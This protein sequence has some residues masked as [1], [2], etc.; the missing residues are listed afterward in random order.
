MVKVVK[1]AMIVMLA[2]VG[3]N[4]GGEGGE[5][6]ELWLTTVELQPPNYR[7]RSSSLSHFCCFATIVL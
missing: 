6:K 7:I 1:I 5:E 2:G 4:G 3:E